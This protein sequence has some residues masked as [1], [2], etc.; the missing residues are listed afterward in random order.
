MFSL[1]ICGGILEASGIAI[2][3]AFI[4]YVYYRVKGKPRPFKQIIK[5]IIRRFKHEH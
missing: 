1:C 3:G 4:A 2:I 5:S